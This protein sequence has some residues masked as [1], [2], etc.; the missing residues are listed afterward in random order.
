MRNIH[1]NEVLIT[2]IY[3]CV[4]LCGLIVNKDLKIMDF[5]HTLKLII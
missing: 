1:W 2:V 4:N 3:S 5:S